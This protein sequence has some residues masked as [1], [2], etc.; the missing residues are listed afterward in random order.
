M[1]HEWNVHLEILNPSQAI[2][3]SRPYLLLGT[4][5]LQKTDVVGCPW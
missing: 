4:D 2:E 5:I 3:N 1:V